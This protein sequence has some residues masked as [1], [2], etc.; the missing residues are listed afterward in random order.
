M[1]EPRPRLLLISYL[2]PPHNAIGA[3]RTG[4][5]AKF[6]S[7]RNWDIRVLAAQAYEPK[8]LPLE[9]PLEQI[10]FT[11]WFDVDK[12]I[13]HILPINWLRRQIPPAQKNNHPE[14]TQSAS[15]SP[16]SFRIMLRKLYCEV[17]RWPD[18]RIGWLP[19]AVSA[20]HNLV[21]KWC[22]DLIYASA[23]PITT[24]LIADRLSRRFG[25]PWIAEFRDL[26]TDHPYY[27]YSRLRRQIEKIWE[28]RVLNRAAALVTVS[29]P[30]Q[31]S[32]QEK[33]GKPT[34]LVMNGYVPEDFPIPPPAKSSQAGP[35]RIVYTGHIYAGYRDPTPL[36]EAIQLL[37]EDKS[38]VIVEFIG[39]RGEAV[40]PLA[41]IAGVSDRIILRPPVSYKDS[42]RI[43]MDA[44]I[45]LHL[46]WNDPHEAGT[47][48][49]KLF[50][51]IGALR[52]ILGIGYEAGSVA[53][54]LRDHE[55][56]F[57]C[58]DAKKIAQH[59]KTWIAL[60]K[61][62]GV[63][64][65]KPEAPIGLTRVEQFQ[66]LEIF[67]K[68]ILESKPSPLVRPIVD[69]KT[70]SKIRFSHQ[71]YFSSIK[72]SAWPRAALT[73]LIDVEEEFDWTKPFSRQNKNVKALQSLP[74]AHKIFSSWGI[75]P[76]YLVD[77]PI[78]NST[79]GADMFRQWVERDE[80]T[81]GAQLHPW[82]NPPDEE[83]IND[84][85]S[86]PGNLPISLE[87]EKLRILTET[88]ERQIGVRPVVYKAGRYGLGAN[89]TDLL[90]ELGYQIDTSMV[91][92]TD[93][94]HQHGP[95]YGDCP[96]GPFWFGQNRRLLELP[97]TRSFTGYFSKLGP[98]IYH[99]IERDWP[100]HATIAGV[101]AQTRALER[102]TLT[103][104]GITFE[105]L[106]RLTVKL[107]QD[108]HKLLTFSFHGPSLR[109]GSTPY[110]RDQFELER[111]LETINRYFEFFF[112][113]IGGVAV[114]PLEIYQR[115]SPIK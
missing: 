71:R 3:L 10:E 102:I 15:M 2:F 92:F 86:Y 97:V 79:F 50:E 111:F 60:K 74:T 62:G 94:S 83:E 113:H 7:D 65:L 69:A 13:E 98:R 66:K 78:I 67:L 84:R 32:L 89:T 6:L 115:L 4:K 80:C 9:I 63:S 23:P 31:I 82:V 38:N 87:K 88:I 51:Y 48:S 56:G 11:S 19:A 36:F 108:G 35:L 68:E 91:P 5:L 61:Q 34:A 59:L 22:P 57:V 44:D 75:R 49:G 100:R 55:A 95:N 96:Y 110:V 37:G 77:Y 85:N 99:K 20:G 16:S 41:D 18:N 104:E 8:T 73:V 54:I 81:V 12:T 58:N 109:P 76:T 64:P 14:V 106:Q 21:D 30:W 52:P 43:Q 26:W 112:R 53:S 25:I 42:L 114:T 39:T 33:F 72:T 47:I 28:R 29:P 70:A 101:L 107:L 17:I 45:L 93:F 105:E 90:E 1:N 27:E 24:L 46:Q 40:K 103:P